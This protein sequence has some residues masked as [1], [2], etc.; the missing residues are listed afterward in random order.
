[1]M[2]PLVILLAVV[3]PQ[4]LIQAVRVDNSVDGSSVLVEP[5]DPSE[6][7]DSFEG[8]AS[9]PS[10]LSR[11]TESLESW[12]YDDMATWPTMYPACGGAMQS[13]IDIDDTLLFVGS[14]GKRSLANRMEYVALENGTV[15]RTA[16]SLFVEGDF[17]SLILPDGKYTLVQLRF[18]F[19]SE[20]TVNGHVSDGEI[21]FFHQRSI[22]GVNKSVIMS[23][24]VRRA[25]TQRNFM[26]NIDAELLRS[27]ASAFQMEDG[28]S[29]TQIGTV[30]LTA[31]DSSFNGGFLHYNGSLTTPPCTENVLWYVLQRQA[32]MSE[33]LFDALKSLSSPAVRRPVQNINGRILVYNHIATDD[34]S[35][36]RLKKWRPRGGAKRHRR[37]HFGPHWQ[38]KKRIN[39]TLQLLNRTSNGVAPATAHREWLP[40][41]PRNGSKD[42]EEGGSRFQPFQPSNEPPQPTASKLASPAVAYDLAGEKLQ[43][44]HL[45][46][47]PRR[48]ARQNFGPRRQR[49]TGKQQ[50][51]RLFNET[52]NGSAPVTAH[53]RW[54][55]AYPR[56][57]L[58]IAEQPGFRFDRSETSKEAHEPATPR[59][60]SA[61]L[62][63]D[64]AKT[65]PKNLRSSEEVKRSRRQAVVPRRQKETNG[66]QELRLFN[67]TLNGSAPAMTSRTNLPAFSRKEPKVLDEA[68]SRFQR[69]ERSNEPAE[70]AA[71]SLEST[72]LAPE[73]A[74][75]MPENLRSREE[76]KRPLSRDGILDLKEPA[77]QKTRRT[78]LSKAPRNGAV[79]GGS[80]RDDSPVHARD[81]TKATEEIGSRF[82]PVEPAATTLA[83][84]TLAPELATAMPEKLRSKEEAKRPLSRDGILDPNE[85]AQQTMTR[86]KRFSK[87]TRNGA[88]SGGSSRDISSV[89]A[90]D[91]TKATEEIGSRFAPAEPA[92]TMPAPTTLAP[93]LATAMPEKLRSI[94]EAKRPLSR[95]GILD[96]NEPAQ[97]TAT[98]SPLSKATWN[99]AVPGESSGDVSPVHA[100]DETKATEEFGSRFAPEEP[101][102]TMLAPTTLAPELANDQLLKSRPEFVAKHQRKTRRH[103]KPRLPKQAVNVSL[104]SSELKD[105]SLTDARSETKETKERRLRLD[106]SSEATERAAATLSPGVLRPLAKGAKEANETAPPVQPS[107]RSLELAGHDEAHKAGSSVQPDQNSPE[108]AR[109]H[110]STRLEMPIEI[111][112]NQAA[113]LPS[114]ANITIVIPGLVSP[115]STAEKEKLKKQLKKER[116]A[117]RKRRYKN[118]FRRR[119]P[120]QYVN[121]LTPNTQVVLGGTWQRDPQLE[122]P[123]L[124]ES[125][126]GRGE[127]SQLGDHMPNDDEKQPEAR[128]SQAK[129][130]SENQSRRSD[131]NPSIKVFEPIPPRKWSDDRL[132]SDSRQ[133]AD[134]RNEIDEELQAR[135]E[136]N[137]KEP[138]YPLSLGQ[139]DG[140]LTFFPK[141]PPILDEAAQEAPTETRSDFGFA[142]NDP[143]APSTTADAGEPSKT[144][145]GL[146]QAEADLDCEQVFAGLRAH[147][148]C[149]DSSTEA[150][151]ATLDNKQFRNDW[152]QGL[153]CSIFCGS[154]GLVC[155]SSSAVIGWCEAKDTPSH[156]HCEVLHSDAF[157]CQCKNGFGRTLG[158]APSSP[159]LDL[160]VGEASKS[161][162]NVGARRQPASAGG[163]SMF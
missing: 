160:R 44:R 30:D 38:T 64:V 77:Q 123:G 78:R 32:V 21:Q 70:L 54:L 63:P 118:K 156:Q 92:A 111:P 139:S 97:Q 125:H 144:T 106:T 9:V 104:P 130:Q 145:S 94:E 151:S 35:E 124:N 18:H 137:E 143:G 90:R 31:F 6:K 68:G 11:N 45:R 101:A 23:M 120:M 66:R 149:E 46:R 14:D 136:Q 36:E 127:K 110:A 140:R 60:T 80:S 161:E 49:R 148:I 67:T 42:L 142:K 157:M 4:D 65:M 107:Q 154:R 162:V 59:V 3:V 53:R 20:H 17:G 43:K 84:T 39:Q 89:H 26:P 146:V 29:M 138:A 108:T 103:R 40:A 69:I 85:P 86:R 1:M 2:A 158:S 96:P 150:C 55:P 22:G 91:E 117:R 41:Y 87:A 93:Q 126:T 152:P 81:E 37:Q 76:A 48:R 28:K 79:P 50:D 102:A 47:E 33:P 133:N 61:T 163:A 109:Y 98:R 132:F 100:R 8:S 58:K 88:V 62:A 74:T 153:S 122:S 72:T 16:N 135:G 155:S 119:H 82:A 71:P 7:L 116:K 73:P 95:D 75:A 51:L 114:V 5:E 83:S 15:T 128:F 56:N 112:R 52:L 57:E 113:T 159:L 121:V 115:E 131:S 141:R 99:G 27:D 105:E 147:Q 24:S 34:P 10:S 19:P 12:S 13:P 25:P 134:L 129:V